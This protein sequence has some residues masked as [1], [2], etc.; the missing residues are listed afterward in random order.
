[1]KRFWGSCLL[2]FLCLPLFAQGGSSVH[3]NADKIARALYY[4]ENRY[5]DTVNLDAMV[6]AMLDGLMAQ[7]DPHSTYIPRDKVESVNES[8]DGSFEGVGIEFAIIADTVTVQRVIAGGPSEA[9]GLRAGDKL[10]EVDGEPAAGVG[11]DTDDV[12]R[13]LRG[14]KGSWVQITIQRGDSRQTFSIRRDTIPL[15]SIDAAYSP[16]PGIVYLKLSRFAQGT[17]DEFI[18]ALRKNAERRPEGI[19]IDLRG[20]GGGFMHVAATIA[21]MFL[22]KGE[23]IVRVEGGGN[24]IFEEDRATGRGFYKE[25]PLVVLVDENSASASEILTGALQDWDRA[26]IVGRKTFGKG[27]IQHQYT[28]PDGSE[29]RL[30]V[31][32][33]HTP[34]GRMVQS[35]YEKGKR[36][37]Y[38][39][40]ARNRYARGESFSLDSIALP[41]SLRYTTLKLGRTVYGGGGILPDVFVPYDTSRYN[42]R[43]L[44][45][46]IGSGALSE[47]TYDYIDKHREALQAENLTDFLALY[48]PMEERVFEG[49]VAYCREKGIEAEAGELEVCEPVLRTRL[50]ALLARS[51]LGLTGYWQVINREEDPA[52]QQALDLIARWKATGSAPF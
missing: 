36:D 44:M 27:L 26:V 5:V 40:Q 34:S 1:M 35:P 14:P 45:R 10:L 20:N 21:D 42:H 51:P 6:D 4:L 15:E 49:L 43:Y 3:R 28:L 33:Y 24:G 16:E 13:L 31:A 23:T 2:L 7:L 32:R 39:S 52:F 41:D 11:I 46:V 47:Y 19:I 50:K 8:L 30:T 18:D 38:Y 48:A 22:E 37:V 9:A 17:V 29:M 12:R 25:G